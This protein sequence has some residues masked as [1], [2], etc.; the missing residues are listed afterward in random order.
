M[1]DKTSLETSVTEKSHSTGTKKAIHIGSTVLDPT[2]YAGKKEKR[3]KT[4]K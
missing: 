3:K 2:L 1:P 4:N